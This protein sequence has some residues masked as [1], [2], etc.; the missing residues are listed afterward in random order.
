MGNIVHIDPEALQS[1]TAVWVGD[2]PRTV[3]YEELSAAAVSDAATAEVLAAIT[4]WPAEHAALS[5]ARGAK[6]SALHGSNASTTSA[7]CVADDDSA[8]KIG[9]VEV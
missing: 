9:T 4:H 5:T 2:V 3:E 8:T 7:L 6:A 1:A